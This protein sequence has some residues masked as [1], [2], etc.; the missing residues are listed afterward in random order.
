VFASARPD[1]N[2]RGLD[3]PLKR[4]NLESRAEDAR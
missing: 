4:E 1:F 3:D 2:E